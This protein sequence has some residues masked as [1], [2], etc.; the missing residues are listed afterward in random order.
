[1]TSQNCSQ[2]FLD[3][4]PFSYWIDQFTAELG[5]QRYSPL[6][7]NGYRDS[8]RH[9]AVWLESADIP[10][11]GIND[12]VVQRFS[13]HHCQ[14]PG[15][16]KHQCIS[17][18]YARRAGKFVVFLQKACVVSTP[19]REVT[20]ACPILDNY[21]HWLRAHRGLSERTI[22]RHLR[23]VHKLLPEL[24]TATHNYD[25][26]RIRAVVHNWRN[27]PNLPT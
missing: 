27:K 4:G 15:G 23:I 7:I 3:P 9:F 14:C 24:G 25:A 8:A 22:A 17:P 26:T 2:G 12:G 10:I 16:R 1:M 5:A 13:A 20:P 6:T 19:P 18:K 11:G 21:Q